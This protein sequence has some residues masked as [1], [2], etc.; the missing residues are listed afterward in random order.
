MVF[1]IRNY[2]S[3]SNA[4]HDN[5]ELRRGFYTIVDNADYSFFYTDNYFAAYFAKMAIDNYVPEYDE[6]KEMMKNREFPAR[7]GRSTK[8]ERNKMTYIINGKDPG[9]LK[10]GYKISHIIDVG[11]NYWIDNKKETI[12]TICD[13]LLYYPRGEY[14][15]W[16]KENGYY[17][18]HLDKVDE[19]AKDILIAHFLRFVHPFNYILTPKK[20]YQK[21]SDKKV[22]IPKNDIGE[23]DRFQ[24]YAKNKFIEI[25]GNE[26]KDYLKMLKYKPQSLGEIYIDINIKK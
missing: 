16:N 12:G 11:D 23:Y 15:D 5:E 4:K 8:E 18:R 25:Y 7:F 21:K 3:W 22:K 1:A 19:K 6:F 13:E 14:T 20:E 17:V 2:N 10:K 26:Y 9:F 24:E